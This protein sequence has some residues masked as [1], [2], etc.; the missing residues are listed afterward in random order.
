MQQMKQSYNRHG[1]GFQTVKEL[2]YRQKTVNE[3]SYITEQQLK[4]DKLTSSNMIN[5]SKCRIKIISI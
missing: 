4:G 1:P 3:L 2:S 5:N